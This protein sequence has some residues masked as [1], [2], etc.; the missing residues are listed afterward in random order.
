M[1]G[2][3]MMFDV[4]LHIKYH[5]WLYHLS[6]ASLAFIQA[7][8]FLSAIV[9]LMRLEEIN[10]ILILLEGPIYALSSSCYVLIY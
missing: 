6:G 7:F 10:L 8:V 3:H 5:M 1:S 2:L 9:S 4:K